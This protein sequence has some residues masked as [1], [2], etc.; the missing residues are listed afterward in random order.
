MGLSAVLIMTLLFGGF[1]M[2]LAVASS[3][4][5]AWNLYNLLKLFRWFQDTDKP[6]PFSI[7]V[8]ETIFKELY[9]HQRQGEIDRKRLVRQI[10]RFERS[11]TALPDG[12]V[13][14]GKKN[15]IEWCNEAAERLLG[16]HR[17]S[18]YGQR[19][20]NLIR[21]PVF[22]DYLNSEKYEIGIEMPAPDE[23]NIHLRVLLVSFGRNQKLLL[24]RNVSRLHHL[25]QMRRDFIANVSHELRTPLTVITGFLETMHASDLAKSPEW[26]R[27]LSLMQEQSTR[28]LSIIDDL[29]FLSKL[30]TD[31]TSGKKEL[32][33]VSGIIQSIREEAMNY[34]G[35]YDHKI[36]LDCDPSLYLRGNQAEIY[37]A[38]SNLI[39]NAVKYT[40]QGGTIKIAWYQTDRGAVFEVQDSGIGIPA[41]HIPRLTER[42]YRVDVGRSREAGG[43]GL[44]LAIVKHVI[45]RHNATLEIDSE[46]NKGSVFRCIF[47]ISLIESKLAS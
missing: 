34:S 11:A 15:N 21:N 4:Y 37:S 32:I 3:L 22:I 14:L 36:E 1:W 28:M 30:E 31:T 19:I 6:P 44:G 7:G 33:N 8:W 12:T 10:E 39:I 23:E 47:P 41:Q 13:I 20:D 24:A 38:F 18:D 9:R 25:E 16:I 26:E 43:T 35:I 42:F 2:W 40:P 45:I 5:I 17:K 29:L 46:I 27:P